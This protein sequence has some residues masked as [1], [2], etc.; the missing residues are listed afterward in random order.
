MEWK[1]VKESLL[2]NK[3][4]KQA[5]ESVDLAHSVGKMVIDARIARK[6]TQQ[7][8]AEL[9]DTKQPSIARIE[10]GISLPSLSFLQ[11]LAEALQTQLLPPRF[12]FLEEKKANA[13][14]NIR[15]VYLYGGSSTQGSSLNWLSSLKDSVS[16]R[17]GG[18]SFPERSK[19]QLTNEGVYRYAA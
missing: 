4:L 9:V 16:I 7:K 18:A 8:L 11:K 19:N 1:E 12:E 13:A 3:D 6:M 10:K 15:I 17:S 14:H 5:Y 2:Q